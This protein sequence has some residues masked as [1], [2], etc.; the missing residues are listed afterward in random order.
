MDPSPTKSKNINFSE[1]IILNV[2]GIRNIV[3][4]VLA[5]KHWKENDNIVL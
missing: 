1:R 2:T 3:I 4:Y 5:I